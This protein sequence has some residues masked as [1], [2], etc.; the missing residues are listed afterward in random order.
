MTSE[1]MDRFFRFSHTAGSSSD[2]ELY[3]GGNIMKKS[4]IIQWLAV[5]V[6]SALVLGGSI[7]L[8]ALAMGNDENASASSDLTAVE[9][10]R[11]I[12]REMGD[13]MV[14]V[15]IDKLDQIFADDWVAIGLSGKMI[16]KEMLLRDFKSAHDKLL[17]YELG[18]IDVQVVGDTAVAHGS[19]TEKRARDGKET[20]GEFVWMDI[21]KKRGGR[22]VVVR[23]AG[24]S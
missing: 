13:A 6:F 23:S 16:T 19:V 11:Q 12:S 15:D 18:P 3:E 17:S 9:A 14:A 2:S 7:K 22:W 21:L 4:A 1:V 10:I 24:A 8:K 5:L 20:S